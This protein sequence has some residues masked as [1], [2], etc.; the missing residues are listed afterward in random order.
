M[1]SVLSNP[2]SRFEQTHVEYEDAPPAMLEVYTDHSKSI[3]TKN[4]SPDVPFAWS[5]N[6]YRGCFHACTYCYAR[7]SHEYLGF[8]AGTDFERKIVVKRDAA[9]LLE[10][11]FRKPSWI[12][13]RVCMSGNT[14]CYQPLERKLGLTR[15]CL[16]V[17]LR[18]RNP[19]GIITK[20][21]LVRRDA[22]LLVELHRQAGV[23]IVVS[24][25]F[26]DPAHSA[27]I[28]PNAPPPAARLA[29][30]RALV[31]AG[32]PVG[33]SVAPVIPG[34]ND[35][36]IPAVL[37]AARASGASWCGMIPVRL[38]GPVQDVFVQRLEQALPADAERV[39]AR[40]RRMRGGRLNRS[41]FGDRMAGMGAE[42]ESTVHLYKLSSRRLGYGRPPPAPAPSPFRVP[43]KGQQIG[44]FS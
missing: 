24:I 1:V 9:S 28:E 26:I 4:T 19:V 3:L 2:P 16:E 21:T 44:L 11:A 42:W 7:P 27:A 33:I 12:G 18:Y 40:I 8:G 13:Q 20:S 38:P 36:Q 32:L 25:P 10:Q 29:T 5:L 34:L 23:A 22:D 6:P 15:A 39:L 30:V 35:V 43:G 31:Q 37:S 17:C 41:G 14:D